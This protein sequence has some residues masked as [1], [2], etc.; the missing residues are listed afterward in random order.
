MTGR[1][2][3]NAEPGRHHR[4]RANPG[5]TQPAAP[6]LL[7]LPAPAGTRILRPVPSS[8][9]FRGQSLVA[10]GSAAAATAKGLKKPKPK[11]KPKGLDG[12]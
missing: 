9:T 3:S 5:C 7:G 10:Q 11:P 4:P 1:A 2:L 12:M 6:Q 8:Q